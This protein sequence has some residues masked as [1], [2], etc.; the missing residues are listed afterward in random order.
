MSRAITTRSGRTLYV[1]HTI[2]QVDG[3]VRYL[4]GETVREARE[5]AETIRN[6]RAMI[7]RISCIV[8]DGAR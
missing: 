8:V 7:E 4:C 1:G 5:I 3:G 2:P 6:D